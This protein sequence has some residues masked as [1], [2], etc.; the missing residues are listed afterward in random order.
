ME[1]YIFIQKVFTM[2]QFSFARIS[3][4]GFSR[5]MNRILFIFHLTLSK[6]LSSMR[7]NSILENQFS[8]GKFQSL[9]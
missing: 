1:K 6:K 4:K 2:M 8:I 9:R 3:F 5:S 7:K